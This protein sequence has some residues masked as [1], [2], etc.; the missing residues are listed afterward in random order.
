MGLRFIRRETGSRS[1]QDVIE[2]RFRLYFPRAFAYAL[3]NLGDE[4]KARTVVM[5]AFAGIFAVSSQMPE[6]Q[7]R[8]ALFSAAR[9]LYKT[10]ARAVPLDFGLSERERDALTLIF[11]ARLTPAEAERVAGRTGLMGD[12]ERGLRRLGTASSP[13][14][15]PSFY[16]AS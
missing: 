10:Q 14:D 7:F 6:E 12:L 3:S 9:D 8:I 15:V 4:E 5:E 16:R 13:A 11:D 1:A 2:K